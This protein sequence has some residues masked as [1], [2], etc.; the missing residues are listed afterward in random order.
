LRIN[1]CIACNQACLDRVFSGE[2]ASCLVNPRA[3]HETIRI[4]QPV[5]TPKRL[6]VIGGGP[7]GMAFAVYAAERG[8]E[9]IV[10]EQ[11]TE[12]GGQ[13]QLACQ[14]PGKAEFADTIRY[15]SQRLHELGVKQVLGQVQDGH[16]LLSLPVDE[17][18]VATGVEPRMP[19]IPGIDHHSVLTYQQLLYENPVLGKRV[20]IMG[21]GGIGFDIA[22]YLL[23][24]QAPS[25]SL[26][27]W[28]AQWG[29][30]TSLQEPG[31]LL[32][33]EHQE[34][35]RTLWLLQRKSGTLG[36]GLGATTGWIQ[37]L[38]LRQAGVHLWSEVQYLNIDDSGLHILHRGER[39][40]LPADQ[41]IICTGQDPCDE[42]ATL[43]T[44]S[45]RPV[46]RIG[47]ARR[48]QEL[49]ARQAILDAFELA[50]VL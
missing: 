12:L 50:M 22:H 38:Q 29:I 48:A 23:Q 44:L 10:Y 31:G 15:F 19:D 34:S 5:S 14:I 28:L 36:A 35:S 41:I 47:G 30:D 2:V 40:I 16:A 45:G 21:A 24:F 32:S 26:E 20:A 11:Q 3:C 49:D 1:P 42:L 25:P 7:A 13:F 46:H 6:A 17:Y 4:L 37:R 8:H 27:A 43:L 39:K 33:P 18:V 9:V